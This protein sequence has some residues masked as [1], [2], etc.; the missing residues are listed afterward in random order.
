MRSRRRS[1][2]RAGCC[3]GHQGG[4]HDRHRWRRARQMIQQAVSKM[5]MGPG[6]SGRLDQH[7]N[8]SMSR[9]M[10]DTSPPTRSPPPIRARV[11]C[12][13]C[14]RAAGRPRLKARI[15]NATRRDR[16]EHDAAAA[17]QRARQGGRAAPFP[18][19]TSLPKRWRRLRS[20]KCARGVAA[21]R[22]RPDH[23]AGP[24]RGP[25]AVAPGR[26]AGRRGV[27][28]VTTVRGCPGPRAQK[29]AGQ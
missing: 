13:S 21:A 29:S 18:R 2:G 1:R 4:R 16:L 27:S 24:V 20:T 19:S 14:E 26:G 8:G 7:A 23:H 5:S 6:R 25:V 22:K 10:Y 12:M 17:G 15:C 3:H 11:P 9:R 28:W